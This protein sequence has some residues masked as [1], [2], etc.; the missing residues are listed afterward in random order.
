MTSL[1]RSLRGIL[2]IALAWGAMWAIIF[3]G[4]TLVVMAARP[5]D[6]GP[7]EGP[8]EVGAIM[9]LVGFLSGL[10]F[11]VLLSLA[12]RGKT[13]LELTLTRATVWGVLGSA[14]YPL[15]TGRADQVVL[16]SALGAILATWV[17]GA[18]RK[19][20]GSGSARQS[21][22]GTV[23]GWLLAFLRDALGQPSHARV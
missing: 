13:A 7:G 8:I 5:Q 15:V 18:A 22:I 16:T 9:G 10:A 2:G 6:I 12:E 17:V 1:L 21:T 20:V 19:G 23:R 14:I 11:G 4:L 3:A